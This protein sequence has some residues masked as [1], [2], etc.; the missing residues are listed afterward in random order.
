MRDGFS[1]IDG[2]AKAVLMP[3]L[4]T[5]EPWGPPEGQSEPEIDA[6]DPLILD[7]AAANM[8][9]ALCEQPAGEGKGQG[10]EERIP[11][12]E[13]AERTRPAARRDA[14]VEA[15]DKWLYRQASK[16]QPP[17]WKAL[18]AELNKIAGTRGWRRLSSA[19]AVEQA[20]RRYIRR[21]GL[22][23]LPRRKEA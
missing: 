6:Q 4:N 8:L 19:Q 22:A 23:P 13:T 7:R 15:R 16:K 20:V 12:S 3:T 5:A 11:V 18:K 21:N 10:S 2:H 17:T 1:S 14:R 9:R